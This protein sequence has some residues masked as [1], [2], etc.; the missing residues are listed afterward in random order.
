M[1]GY[2]FPLGGSRIYINQLNIHSDVKTFKYRPD[3][4]VFLLFI[5]TQDMGD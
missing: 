1:N 2:H 3:P 5:E 4:P